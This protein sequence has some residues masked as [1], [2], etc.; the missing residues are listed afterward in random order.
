MIKKML[1]EMKWVTRRRL[2]YIELMAYYRGCVSRKDIARA[3]GISGAAATKDLKFYNDTVPGNLSYRH[4]I[5]G[6]VPSSTFK[7]VFADLSPA[8]VLPMMKSNLAMSGGP[9]EKTS[10][11]G[12]TVDAL[13]LPYR[14]PTK[15]VLC[16]ITR[17]I[18]NGKKLCIRYYSHTDTDPQTKRIIEPHALV[19]TGA[20][21]HVRAYNEANY[22]FRD[23]V[24]SRFADARCLNISAESSPAYDDDW[25]E[26]VTLLL[27]PHPGLNQTQRAG[28][29]F[30]LGG[31]HDV[32]EIVTRRALIGYVLQWFGVDNSTD[33]SLN[34]DTYPL[35]IKNRDEVEA[36]AAGA[37]SE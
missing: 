11:F 33:Y 12:V 9:D 14:L 8:V 23:F 22:D 19:N 31:K 16:Q 10:V 24:L 4:S 20:R 15:D 32:I 34:P 21:W 1:D 35:V 13:V 6:F 7:E 26:R 37:L 2:E 29:L 28:L 5:F 25:V 18:H 3:F 36:F 17:A 30:D 27:S